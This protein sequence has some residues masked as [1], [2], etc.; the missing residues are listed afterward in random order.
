MRGADLRVGLP[1]P[2]S[3]LRIGRAAAQGGQ[4]RPVLRPCR[5]LSDAGHRVPFFTTKEDSQRTG[6]G[7]AVAWSVAEEHGGSIRVRSAEGEGAEF[8]LTLPM[9]TAQREGVNGNRK[10][11]DCG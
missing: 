10:D 2:G 11:P 8:V 7:L 9:E 4:V 5:S 1:V 3:D 6:L